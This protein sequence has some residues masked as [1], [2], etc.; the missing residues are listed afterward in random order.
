MNTK[1]RKRRQRA[2]RAAALRAIAAGRQLGKSRITAMWIDEYAPLTDKQIAFMQR[3]LAIREALGDM[4]DA[5]IDA[6]LLR[7]TPTI[8]DIKEPEL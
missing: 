4:T 1:K 2:D 3:H 7:S 8:I 6:F 5:E